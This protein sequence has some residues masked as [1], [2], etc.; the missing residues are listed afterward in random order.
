[1]KKLSFAILL[2]ATAAIAVNAQEFKETVQ[3]LSKKAEKGYVY[4]VSKDEGGTSYIT[5]KMK[6]DKNSEDIS[7]EEY[8]FDKNLKFLE[9]KDTKEK[10]EQKVDYE[11]TSYYATVG[12]STSFDVLS[13]KLKL[14]KVVS[15]RTW[16]NENQKFITKKVLS[17]ETIK[18]RNDGGKTFNGYAS[19]VS[20]DDN[21]NDVF[22]IARN[23]SKEKNAA[24]NYY[25]L[26]F[27]D[28]LEITEKIVDLK[29]AYSLVFC[30]QLATDNI[31]LVF[32]PKKGAADI[33]KYVY[34]QYDMLG[35]QIN[36]A[37]FNSPASALL[38]TAAY[39]KDGDVYFC[40]SSTGSKESYEKLFSE[41]APIVSPGFT[42][43]ANNALDLKWEKGAS[44]KMEQF[45]LFKF[46]A[47]TLSFASTTPVAEFKSK[48]KTAPGDKG[49]SAYN[50]KK[51]LIEQFTVTASGDYLIAGQLTAKE[52]VGG[53][54][55]TSY[56]DI[57][58]FHFDKSGSLKAQYGIGKMNMDKKSEIFEMKQNFHLASD[59]K[60]IYWELL[61]VKGTK[62]YESFMDAYNGAPTFYALYFPRICKID[63]SNSSLGAIKVLGGEKYFLKKYFP[64]VF[65][66]SENSI[67]YIGHDDDWKNLW[68]GKVVLQ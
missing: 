28:K 61:E 54:L 47:N 15:L 44:E 30:E 50:G 11:R 12:G 7:Y 10:K 39:E 16:S 56:G 1:M 63:L 19:Y 59:G 58:S 52:N 29:G 8:S 3:L 43:S 14:T 51:F 67:T 21:K 33:S 23:E 13:M 26:L 32:A 38:L 66:K 22:I 65:D 41:Y 4:N 31:V 42:G 18:P 46:S 53:T 45:H 9:S 64:S 20:S 57:V 49:A 60:S 40:G 6:L 62:G 27:N 34:V 17:R 24:D 2:I 68:L 25:V 37:E 35:N 48:F 5:Y 36:R 55:V